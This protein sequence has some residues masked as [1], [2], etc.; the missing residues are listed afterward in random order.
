MSA[1][2]LS[3]RRKSLCASC[4]HASDAALSVEV[5]CQASPMFVPACV[6]CSITCACPCLPS[7][8]CACACQLH[9]SVK[10]IFVAPQDK[11]ILDKLTAAWAEFGMQPPIFDRSNKRFKWYYVG[12]ALGCVACVRVCMC[13]RLCACALVCVCARVC[14]RASM[15]VCE[16][17]VCVLARV[18]KCMCVWVCAPV[19]VVLR[20]CVCMRLRARL[21]YCNTSRV[22]P[23]LGNEYNGMCLSMF[24]FVV[25]DLNVCAHNVLFILCENAW[26]D[27]Y[28]A[29][30]VDQCIHQVIY[31]RPDARMHTRRRNAKSS[32]CLCNARVSDTSLYI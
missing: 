28:V 26:W 15:H 21:T 8:V 30:L 2:A 17:C 23:L 10:H 31:V 6:A 3:P 1:C 29:A 22:H 4:G 12:C 27:K 7:L 14:V 16:A 5:L 25:W 24:A 19:H 9:R 11:K 18:R 20:L 32:E 13:S